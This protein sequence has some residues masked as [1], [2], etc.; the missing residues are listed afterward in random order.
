MSSSLKTLIKQGISYP[1]KLIEGHMQ[2]PSQ[3][4]TELL[5]GEGAII[6]I[7]GKKV[8]AYKNEAGEL[9]KLS[10]VC[11]HLGCIVG[12]NN[13]DKTW[14][15]PCHGSRYTKEGKVMNWPAQRDLAPRE[16]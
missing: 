10:P 6:D 15:C 11:T 5:P 13:T 4:E 16:L 2:T 14:D 7:N 8:A 9:I 1:K 12:W 3:T